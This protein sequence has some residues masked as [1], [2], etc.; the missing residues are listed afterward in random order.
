MLLSLEL[1]RASDGSCL[2]RASLEVENL[3]VPLA[4]TAPTAACPLRGRDTPRMRSGYTRRLDDLPP[5][6][7]CVRL[8]VAVRRFVRPRSELPRHI[9]TDRLPGFAAP[10]ARTTDRLRQTQTDIGPALGGPDNRHCFSKAIRHDDLESRIVTDP[11]RRDLMTRSSAG[12]RM[13]A[14][15]N[16]GH[17]G[18]DLGSMGL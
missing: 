10:R 14:G 6:G 13:G 9:F 16:D 17:D 4:T 5:L 15:T 1:P 11:S 12:T 8:Q 3:S 18:N 7:R 2:V